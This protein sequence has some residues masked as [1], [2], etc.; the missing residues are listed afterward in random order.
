VSG[1]SGFSATI[2]LFCPAS[3]FFLCAYCMTP[4]MIE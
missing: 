3:K 4:F 2:C 1:A